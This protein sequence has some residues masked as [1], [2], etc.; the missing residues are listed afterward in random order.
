MISKNQSKMTR[1]TDR[2]PKK[3][4]IQKFV[5]FLFQTPKI[6]KL[7]SLFFLFFVLISLNI[8]AQNTD[9]IDK[10]VKNLISAN[11]ITLI[12]GKEPSFG[13]SL[14]FEKLFYQYGILGISGQFGFGL[15]STNNQVNTLKEQV[16]TLK[17]NFGLNFILG[18]KNHLS[19]MAVSN[20][21]DTWIFRYGYRYQ[22]P[23]GGFMGRI[24]L[25]HS[26]FNVLERDMKFYNPM[27]IE[28]GIGWAF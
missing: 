25:V 7:K 20:T 26:F 22:K 2:S 17:I 14:M 13:N 1:L 18:R 3:Q 28:L 24:G 27:G 19:E 9:K 21:L 16:N 6:M 5:S 11:N 15:L 12:V 8:F 10:R 23:E 4:E